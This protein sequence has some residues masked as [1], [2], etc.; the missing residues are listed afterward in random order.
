[1]ETDSAALEL[2]LAGDRGALQPLIDRWVPIIHARAARVIARGGYGA[3]PQAQQER[4]DLV[5][6]VFVSLFERGG[7]ALKAW[8]SDGGLSLDNW[9]GLLAERQV[10]SILRTGKRNPWTEEVTPTERLDRASDAVDP[11]HEAITTDVLARLLDRLQ[12]ELTP[13]GWQVFQRLYV[14]DE[15]VIQVADA[16]SMSVDAVYAWRSR[17]RRRSRALAQEL[18]SE[19]APAARTTRQGTI[20]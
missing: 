1:M 18:L 6:E 3:G 11:E 5:Q 8:R 15:D 14:A 10:L 19:T 4:E 12:E 2:A 7:R 17:L 9:I 13:L 20:Q 16:L